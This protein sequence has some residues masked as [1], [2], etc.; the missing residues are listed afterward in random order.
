MNRVDTPLSGTIQIKVNVSIK[1]QKDT[2]EQ[3]AGSVLSIQS[4]LKLVI[5]FFSA[6]F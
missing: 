2:V 6:C 4:N 3:P 5:T 1:M